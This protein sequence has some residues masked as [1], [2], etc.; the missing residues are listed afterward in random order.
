MQQIG[1]GYSVDR[2]V[3]KN[4]E[5]W[6]LPL[7][8]VKKG[9][10]FT[11]F[12]SLAGVEPEDIQ[13]SIEEG[14]LTIKGQTKADDEGQDAD[15]LMRERREGAFCRALRLPD[16]LDIDKAHTHYANGVLSITFPRVEA[17]KAKRLTIN[18]GKSGVL[19]GSRN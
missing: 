5:G 1:R 8:V 17:Q 3:H 18:T 4:M 10:D 19:E 11:I 9:D 16:S 12:A 15:Y 13:V 14:V 6:P 7:D 2:A